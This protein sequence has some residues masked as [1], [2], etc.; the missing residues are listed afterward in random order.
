MDTFEDFRAP[1][2]VWTEENLIEK[3]FFFWKVLKAPSFIY[4]LE[5]EIRNL[6]GMCSFDRQLKLFYVLG[7][8]YSLGSKACH[9][10]MHNIHRSY[11]NLHVFSCSNY[12]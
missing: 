6:L 7:A 1:E 11:C 12:M 10:S 8:T 9:V 5:T 4:R 2:A 3:P